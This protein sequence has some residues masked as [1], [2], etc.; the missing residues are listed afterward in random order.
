MTARA[1][2]DT[3]LIVFKWRLATSVCFQSA[4][5]FI[6]NSWSS[7]NELGQHRIELYNECCVCLADFIYSR[8]HTH[9]CL[10]YKHWTCITT[11]SLSVRNHF[12]TVLVVFVFIYTCTLISCYVCRF[13][14]RVEEVLNDWKLIGSRVGNP[15]E[16]V[17][18]IYT[19]TFMGM[20]NMPNPV[21][22]TL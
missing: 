16:K 18:L 14:S 3:A 6:L 4:Q 1:R 7:L 8:S 22:G 11:N 17:N 9:Q 2:D 12:L 21:L 13:I 19:S 15:P 10:F 20:K 5:L